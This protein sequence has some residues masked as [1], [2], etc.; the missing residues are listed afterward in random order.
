MHIS[1]AHSVEEL[2][3]ELVAK[4]TNEQRI[5]SYPDWPNIAYLHVDVLVLLNV[6]YAHRVEIY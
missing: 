5:Y 3:T 2:T 6:F 1:P 4:L